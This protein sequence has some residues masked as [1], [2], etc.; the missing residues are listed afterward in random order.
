MPDTPTPDFEDPKEMYA[1]FGLA[2]YGANLLESSLV[3]W[4][5]AL[6]LGGINGAT[7]QDFDTVFDHFEARKLGQLLGA[8][9]SLT[10]VPA[11]VDSALA[12]ALAERNRL[13][14]R[15]FREHAENA[16]HPVGQRIVIGEL[17][18]MI[19][20]FQKADALVTP[21]YLALWERFGVDQAMIEREL[22]QSLRETEAKYSGL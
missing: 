10:A 15:F 18:S 12:N 17:S 20:L 5:V 4:M 2:V 7:R 11:S 16:T 22:E 1:F 21:I 3:N 6:H 9:R 19:E 14:H 13:I 8:T